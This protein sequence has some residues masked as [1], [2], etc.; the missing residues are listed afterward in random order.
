MGFKQGSGQQEHD[1]SE[2]V[3]LEKEQIYQIENGSSEEKRKY[4]RA[5]LTSEDADFL[6]DLTP[7]QKSAIY[8]KVDVRVVPMLAL[9]YLIAHLDRANIGNAK[10]EGMEDDLGM[11]GTDYNIAVATFFVSYILFEVPSNLLLGKFKRPSFYIGSLVLAW[12]LVMTCC[13]FV[14]NFSSLCGCRFLIGLFE[15][16]FFPGSMWLITQWYPPD[17]TGFR[18]SLFYF[19]SAASGAFSGLLAAGITKMDGLGGQ[20]GWRWIFI[21]EGL[22][23]VAIGVTTFFL[24]PDTPS[25]SGRWLKP[26]E[27]RFLNLVHHATRGSARDQLTEPGQK[28]RLVKWSTVKAVL[29][30]KHIYLQALV[31]MSNSVPNY[32]LKFTMPQIIRNMGF[33]STNAQLL[34][35]PPYFMGAFSAIAFAFGSDRLAWRMP[36]V[37]GPQSLVIIAYSVLFVY[38]AQIADNVPLCYVMVVIACMGV[39]PIIPAT[40]S[41]TINNLAGAEK[42]NMGSGYFIMLGNC[43]GIVG[44]FIFLENEKPK[45]PTGFGSSLAFGAAGIVAALTVEYFYWSHN[46]KYERITEEEANEQ[47]GRAS[48]DKMGDR[49]PLFKYQL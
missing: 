27:Q 21:I 31:Y 34:T 38:A 47:F 33:T 37:L 41:W 2:T 24:L 32:A 11:S 43:G 3:S 29:T 28:K 20:E 16:G 35:A 12:G 39:Y 26:E 1:V 14:Q 7:K 4:L 23:S 13:G 19:S 15:A 44:S 5:G 17:R 42:R 8:H 10:I 48:I 25:L 6:L 22:A 45:Y 40:N 49:S 18:M 46:K 36:F 9:L 30:D